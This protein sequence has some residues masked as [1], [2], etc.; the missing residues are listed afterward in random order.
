MPILVILF[1]IVTVVNSLQ[2]LKAYV[3]MLVIESG[4]VTDKM[5]VREAKAFDAMLVTLYVAPSTTKLDNKVMLPEADA[6]DPTLADT[7]PTV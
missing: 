4:I 2:P 1:D 3:P 7:V 5:V 6:L